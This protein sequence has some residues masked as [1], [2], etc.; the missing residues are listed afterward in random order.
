MGHHNFGLDSGVVG[1]GSSGALG[2]LDDVIQTQVD[3]ASHDHLG[4]W[5]GV[6]GGW[7]RLEDVLLRL[8]D[9][10]GMNLVRE[11]G[12]IYSRILK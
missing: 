2:L 7:T 4:D 1:F 10:S 5:F 11:I 9:E 8:E 6:L 12:R 3:L